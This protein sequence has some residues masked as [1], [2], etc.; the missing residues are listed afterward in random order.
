MAYFKRESGKRHGGCRVGASRAGVNLALNQSTFSL[1]H[2]HAVKAK[3]LDFLLCRMLI[4]LLI[5]PYVVELLA[6]QLEERY[7]RSRAPCRAAGT[8]SKWMLTPVR[9]QVPDV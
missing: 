6:S 8:E 3:Q 7:L 9:E 1:G 5:V 4:R 2:L